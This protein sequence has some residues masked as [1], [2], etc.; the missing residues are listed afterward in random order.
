MRVSFYL[1]GNFLPSAETRDAWAEGRTALAAEGK[2]A[3]AQA[4]IYRTWAALDAAG[5][6][7]ELVDEIPRRG[8]VAA[9]ASHLPTGFRPARGLFLAGI[10]A[11]ALPH[12]AAHAHIVQN[13]AHANRLRGA[14]FIPH[15]P[16]PG[17]VPRDPA[18]GQRFERIAYIGH[19]DNLAPELKDAAWQERLRGAC[20]ATFEMCDAGRWGD[21]SDVDAVIAVRAFRGRRELHKPATKL[22]NAWLAGA[23]FIGGEESAYASDGSAGKNYLVARS[24]DE[25]IRL[26][27][28]LAESPSL[29]ASLA[30]HGLEAARN[31]NREATLRRW[32]TLVAETLPEAALREECKGS[33]ARALSSGARRVHVALDRRLR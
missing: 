8:I 30:R 26:A 20:G 29:R 21:Y 16:Q 17:L 23:P 1:P 14:F 13:S 3:T 6:D 32:R 31:F 15:W 25:V 12:P 33:L 27:A 10:V 7:V 2:I 22:Y 18:R 28:R 4:W 24:P 11:D 5:E 19:A 9:M